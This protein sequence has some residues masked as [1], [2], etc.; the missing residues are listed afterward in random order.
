MPP[1]R[2]AAASKA[3]TNHHHRRLDSV[4][5]LQANDAI[6]KSSHIDTKLDRRAAAFGRRERRIFTSVRPEESTMMTNLQLAHPATKL[7]R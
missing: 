4:H 7:T 6:D 5:G 1:T 3:K 2:T